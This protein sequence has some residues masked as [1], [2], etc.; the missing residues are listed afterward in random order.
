M[1]A[2]KRTYKDGTTRWEVRY[3]DPSGRRRGQVFDRKADAERFD[4]ERRRERQLRRG[5]LGPPATDRSVTVDEWLDTW[6]E[7]PAHPMAPTTKAQRTSVL[8]KW[9]RPFL[10]GYQLRALTRPVLSDW[11]D[12]ILDQDA[13]AVNANRARSA[14]SASL[15]AAADRGLVDANPCLGW[16]AIPEPKTAAKRLTVVEIEA[17]RARVPSARDRALIAVMAYCGLRPEEAAGLQWQDVPADLSVL[18]VRR[19]LVDGRIGETKTKT[20]RVVPAPPAVRDDLAQLDRGTP[21]S[22]VFQGVNGG[23]IPF[24]Y[25]QK[26]VWTKARLEA[27]IAK[28]RAYDLRHSAA[29]AWLLSGTPLSVVH[30]SIGHSSIN[31]T[32][33][34]YSHVADEAEHRREAPL[35]EQIAEARPK[36]ERE[37]AIQAQGPSPAALDKLAEAA[38]TMAQRAA[39][40]TA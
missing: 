10:G 34:H 11:R 23:P 7:S 26:T 39:A 3:I 20:L 14:L 40:K 37:A 18:R 4:L 5:G 38:E 17:I 32:L 2:R 24:D 36:A 8:N 30:R 21:A 22:Y 9:V 1:A 16:R 31:T 6:L 19:S 27:G 25:W 35:E 28:A 15:S 33:R 13:G 29:T 12:R